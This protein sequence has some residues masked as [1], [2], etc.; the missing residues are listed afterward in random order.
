MVLMQDEN[1]QMDKA[2]N[3]L[4]DLGFRFNE[5]VQIINDIG[6]GG[7]QIINSTFPALKKKLLET[8]NIKLITVPLFLDWFQSY[9]QQVNSAKGLTWGDNADRFDLLTDNLD[10]LKA[11]IPSQADLQVIFNRVER[12]EDNVFR[13]QLLDKTELLERIKE[14][15]AVLPSPA[16]LEQLGINTAENQR[17]IN[18]LQKGLIE[19][20]TRDEVKYIIMI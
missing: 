5:A 12:V 8:Y 7:Q 14:I 19:M 1:Y 15:Y 3:N 20:P 4:Q 16:D 13:N 11:L 9:A 10:D 6:L 18:E 17:L 2:K